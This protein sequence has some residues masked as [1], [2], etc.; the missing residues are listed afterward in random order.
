MVKV[1]REDEAL[2]QML[3]DAIFLVSPEG[4]I[5]RAT[6]AVRAIFGYTPEELEGR[7]LD[8]L[9]PDAVRERHGAFC[10]A[11]QERPELRPMGTSLQISGRRKDGSEL[12]LD[13]KLTPLVGREATPILAV[14]RDIAHIRRMEAQLEDRARELAAQNAQ[15]DVLNEERN[16]LLGIAAH[17]LRNPLAAIQGFARLLEGEALGP[18]DEGQV[19]LVRNISRS[20]EFML[21][22]VNDLLDF[23]A[24]ESGKVD[25]QCEDVDLA[26]L[27]QEA[28]PVHRLHADEKS[29]RIELVLGELPPTVR[30]DPRKIEQ[31]LHNLIGNAIK[32][33]PERTTIAVAVEEDGGWIQIDVKDEG[34]G[35][36]P[37]EQAH[38]FE[39]FRR[40][41]GGAARPRGTGL[42]LAIV[43]RI[44]EGHGGTIR[45]SSQLGEGSTFTVLLPA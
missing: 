33:S 45:V 27:V 43:L 21:H 19:E 15:L 9:V 16:R 17:D 13:I 28:L 34:Q 22:L 23:A 35:I 10:A 41:G 44:V 31:V 14:V 1:D 39:P 25:V 18:L 20:S 37:E 8:V 11:F 12:P 32:Y 4:R 36:A 38:L 3:P 7:P 2:L 5:A 24:L 29:I 30:L 40:A 6:G 42:G 26:R